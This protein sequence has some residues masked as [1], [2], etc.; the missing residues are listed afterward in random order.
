LLEIF[1]WRYRTGNPCPVTSSRLS[2]YVGHLR[3]RHIRRDVVA[4]VTMIF[5]IQHVFEQTE[6]VQIDLRLSWAIFI[7]V[8]LFETRDRRRSSRLTFDIVARPGFVSALIR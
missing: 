2:E 3:L 7:S 8:V 4:G 5:L 1:Q 6:S